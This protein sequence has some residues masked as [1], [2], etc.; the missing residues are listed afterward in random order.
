MNIS[1]KLLS[2]PGSCELSPSLMADLQ[3]DRLFSEQTVEVLQRPCDER[4]ILRRQELFALLRDP[5]KAGRLEDCLSLL[6][7]TERAYLLWQKAKTK[8]EQYHRTHAMWAAYVEVCEALAALSDL[9]CALTRELA[10]H[11][12]T[13][14]KRGLLARLRTAL[15][16]SQAILKTVRTGLLSCSD[17]CWL[18]PDCASESER[19]RIAAL[20]Q[21]LGFSVPDP[22]ICR[23]E[24]P[25]S[26][27][28]AIFRL[29]R[30]ECADWELL[31]APFDRTLI[32]EP[33]QYIPELRFFLEVHALT[34]R[35]GA[36]GIPCCFPQVAREPQYT[37]KGLYDI[38]LWAKTSRTIV[39]TDAHFSVQEPFFFLVGANGGGKTTYLRAVGI[40]L[41]LF[42]AGC[43]IF[44]RE[45][46]IYPFDDV[47]AHF[48][49]D[50][51]FERVGRL[52]EELLRTAAM[53]D[54]A[55]GKR[56][57]L[58][59][60]ETYSGTDDRRG[61]DLLRET[62]DRIHAAGHSGLYVTHFH[63]VMELEYPVLRAEVVP[64]EDHRRTYRIVK[65]KGNAA[66]FAADILKKYRL[67]ADSL[68]ERRAQDEH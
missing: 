18:T 1:P 3:I 24:L 17:K 66:S 19:E 11:F 62:V 7:H 58:L 28:D 68:R 55:A 60:N 32:E 39:P 40:N 42:L 52:D 38:V 22:S 63:E 27:S 6:L 16:R 44:A 9:G 5:K 26:L 67:D 2:F 23:I 49:K 43:P 41:V 45:A 53:L 15:N 34:E 4:E 25:S 31:F 46:E 59:F 8:V 36:I 21:R 56:V 65:S 12:D 50:E 20:A 14:E 33:L 30:E 51:R 37:A 64:D 57:F 54:R 47:E 10:R 29:Y 48:P 61:F 13:E 35:A